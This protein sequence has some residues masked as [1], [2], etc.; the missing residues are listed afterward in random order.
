MP[1]TL[2]VLKKEHAGARA[3]GAPASRVLDFLVRFL[4]E[5][6]LPDLDRDEKNSAGADMV[7]IRNSLE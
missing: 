4:D 5:V 6:L 1:A 3:L 2:L 7:H